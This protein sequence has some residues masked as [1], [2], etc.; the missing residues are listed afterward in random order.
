[1]MED[2]HQDKLRKIKR[3]LNIVCHARLKCSLT[4]TMKSSIHHY[5]ARTLSIVHG[6]IFHLHAYIIQFSATFVL[7]K[8]GNHVVA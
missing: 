1:M 4:L 5:M 6:T 7:L 8:I 2:S 3:Y